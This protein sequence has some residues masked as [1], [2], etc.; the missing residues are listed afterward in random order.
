MSKCLNDE[1]RELVEKNHNLIY[2][3]AKRHN[4]DVEEHYDILAIGLCK[5]ASTYDVSTNNK[6]STLAERCMRN[7]FNSY[8]R[9]TQKKNVIPVNNIVSYDSP[10]DDN[11][12]VHLENII[13]NNSSLDDKYISKE[14]FNEMLSLLTNR[15]KKIAMFFLEGVPVSEI[16]IILE[17]DPSN[18][19][20]ARGNIRKKLK[21]YT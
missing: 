3:Y 6:F 21:A 16:A 10:S 19:R 1:Q 12:G 2:G 17:C 18:I 14:L 20:H 11:E 15:E 7:E 4:I 9:S 8:Y 5:A 13:Y